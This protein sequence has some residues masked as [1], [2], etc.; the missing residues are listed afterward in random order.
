MNKKRPVG[1]IVLA[2]INFIFGI[3]ELIY[4]WLLITSPELQKLSG[5]TNILYPV[6]SILLISFLSIISGIGFIMLNYYTGYIGGII[7]SSAAILN[8]LIYIIFQNS[9]NLMMTCAGAIYPIIVISLLV[10]RYKEIFEE[11]KLN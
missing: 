5:Y 1:L 8:I 2:I 11:S 6:F 7:C 9:K 4:L 10:V 3:W